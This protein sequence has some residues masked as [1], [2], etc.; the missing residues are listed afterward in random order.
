MYFRREN[1]II[2]LKSNRLVLISFYMFAFEGDSF[3]IYRLALKECR[4]GEE[5]TCC[6]GVEKIKEV[7]NDIRESACSHQTPAP[8]KIKT[9]APSGLLMEPC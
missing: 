8:P 4:L 2:V 3:S 6:N 5:E 7:F 1:I 9:K